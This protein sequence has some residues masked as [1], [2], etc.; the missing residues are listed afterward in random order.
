MAVCCA[1]ATSGS[2]ARISEYYAKLEPRTPEDLDTARAALEEVIKFLKGADS[3]PDTA[4]W[5]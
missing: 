5:S 3:V 4:F 2:A 1:A